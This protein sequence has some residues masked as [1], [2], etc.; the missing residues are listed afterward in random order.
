MSNAR[1]LQSESGGTRRSA[2][3]DDRGGDG[4]RAER[5]AAVFSPV[6]L[7]PFILRG[8]NPDENMVIFIEKI[9]W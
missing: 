8:T 5:G 9:A 1:K 4:K 7:N 6:M 2:E 3:S